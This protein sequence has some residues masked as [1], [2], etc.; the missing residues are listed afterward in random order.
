MCQTG[1][2]FRNRICPSFKREPHAQGVGLFGRDDRSRRSPQGA[3]YLRVSPLLCEKENRSE[4][5]DAKIFAAHAA[6]LGR[7]DADIATKEP[8]A[9]G[10]GLFGR[11]DRS[12]RSPQGARYLRRLAVAL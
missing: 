2:R 1:N 10:V 7:F 3:R 4:G 9:Q 12:R 5:R 11:D 6:K 8:H